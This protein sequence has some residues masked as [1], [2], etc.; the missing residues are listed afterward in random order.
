MKAKLYSLSTSHPSHAA[1]GMLERKGIDYQI[2]DLL[3]GM[4]PILLRAAGFRG[5]TVPALKLNG[6]KSQ[7]SL[8]IS[9]ALDRAWP[10]PPL[11]P[12]DP[13]RRRAVEQAEAWGEAELQPVPRRLFRWGTVHQP[14]LRRWLAELSGMPLPGV[15]ATVNAPVARRFA[16]VV[17]ASDEG[18]RADLA[19]LPRMLDRADQLI[20]EGAIGGEPNAADFQIASSVRVLLQFGDL[21]PAVDGRPCAELARR[22]FPDYPGPIPLRLEPEWLAVAG[23]A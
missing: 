11:F 20:E 7:G 17:E 10:Q 21:R 22:L 9:R 12:N 14:E 23:T 19:A 2:I 5:G 6:A 4:H 15:A 3:P 1:R 13:E 18:V 16:R 8:R